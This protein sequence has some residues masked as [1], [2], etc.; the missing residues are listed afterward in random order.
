[1]EGQLLSVIRKAVLIL[2]LIIISNFVYASP[3]NV[4]QDGCHQ[5]EVR[6][7]IN[8]PDHAGTSLNSA[9]SSILNDTFGDKEYS[10]RDRAVIL[11]ALPVEYRTVIVFYL[12]DIREEKTSQGS[13]YYVGKFS[14]PYHSWDVAVADIGMHNVNAAVATERAIRYF[15]PKVILLVG[16]AGGM[17]RT[18]V[19]DV[20]IASKIYD[21]ESGVTEASSFKA[22]PEVFRP[23]YRILELARS[24]ADKDDWLA[25]LRSFNESSNPKVYVGPVASGEKVIASTKCEVYDSLQSYYGDAI[26]VEMEGAGFLE[27]TYANPGVEALVLRGISDLLDD[28]EAKEHGQRQEIASQDA[29]AFAF[30]VL[31]K[32]DAQ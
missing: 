9:S 21:Y 5:G 12:T 7:L 10:K 30:D 2:H 6:Q 20:V 19:G 11:T 23:T 14:S 28:D 8:S 16:T 3:I 15:D 18:K 24:E 22:W 17:G 26:A 31:S 27:A 25:I 13:I 1:M 4:C 32:L 29:S